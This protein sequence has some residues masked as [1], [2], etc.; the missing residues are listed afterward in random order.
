MSI[1][2][3][4]LEIIVA[5]KW[6]WFKA[7]PKKRFISLERFVDSWFD[8]LIMTTFAHI[9]GGIAVAAAAQHF[10]FKEEIAPATILVGAFLGLLPDLDTLFALLFG[11]W[12]PGTEMLSHH[13][14]FTHTPVFYLLI[15]GLVWI[16]TDWKWAV[17]FLSVTLSHL[18]LDSWS[19]DDGILWLWPFSAKQYS[20]FP[21]DTHAGGIYGWR[22]Y[23]QYFRNPRLILPEVII[24]AAGALVIIRFVIRRYFQLP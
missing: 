3:Y 7:H 22:F 4:S 21:M 6:I 24:V 16:F 13:R 5:I 20:L 1:E 17:L 9:G 14:Y 2:I 18:L 10:V 23:W 15:S 11:K 19:T 12:S 8:I